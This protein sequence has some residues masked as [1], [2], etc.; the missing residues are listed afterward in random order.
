MEANWM[1]TGVWSDAGIAPRQI[2]APEFKHRIRNRCAVAIKHLTANLN[3]IE[4]R[5]V[6]GLL[7]NKVFQPNAKIRTHGLR[8]SR[9][10]SGKAHRLRAASNGVSWEPRKTISNS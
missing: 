5:I 10:Q 8:S 2:P 9:D 6:C 7:T 4:C 1:T 3:R